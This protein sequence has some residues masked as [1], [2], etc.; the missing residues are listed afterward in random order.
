MELKRTTDTK[1]KFPLCNNIEHLDISV[2]PN[3]NLRS[4]YV[5]GLGSILKCRIL[6]NGLLRFSCHDAKNPVF[7][8]RWF[9]LVIID[10]NGCINRKIISIPITSKQYYPRSSRLNSTIV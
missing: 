5:D 1:V 8:E 3:R 7:E 10:E 2:T 9:A 4:C 6:P